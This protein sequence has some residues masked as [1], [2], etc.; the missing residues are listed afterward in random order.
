MFRVTTRVRR[1]IETNRPITEIAAGA[2]AD[3]YQ[4]MWIDGLAKALAGQIP[5]EE[6]CKVRSELDEISEKSAAAQPATRIAA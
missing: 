2:A 6:L 5:A 4:P 3:G 1:L